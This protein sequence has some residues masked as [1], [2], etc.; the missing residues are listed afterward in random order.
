MNEG[1]VE[2][3]LYYAQDENVLARY[4]SAVKQADG[5]TKPGLVWIN[6]NTDVKTDIA[7]INAY[8]DGTV[9]IE[10]TKINNAIDAIQK[11]LGSATAGHKATHTLD[12]QGNATATV[13]TVYK[14]IEDEYDRATGAEELLQSQID[15]LKGTGTGS[16]GALEKALNDEIKNRETADTNINNTIGKIYGGTIPTT[17]EINT[18]TKNANAISAIQTE[19]GTSTDNENQDTVY[20]AIAAE[21]V[22]A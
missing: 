20:G 11:V 9:K 17:G 3:V 10:L 2:T 18:I 19:I 1:L 16:L 4:S 7:T 21:Q 14:S 12:D 15:T 6:D 22:R 13:K 5:S 8:L